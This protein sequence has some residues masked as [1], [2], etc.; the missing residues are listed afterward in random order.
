MGLLWM[1]ASLAVYIHMFMV[2][3]HFTY[4][5]RFRDLHLLYDGLVVEVCQFGD[6]H[7]NG[8][9]TVYIQFTV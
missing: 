1:C 6:Q 5:L 3:I 2:Y 9:H 8:L 4:S 7:V